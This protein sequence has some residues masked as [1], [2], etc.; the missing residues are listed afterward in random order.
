MLMIFSNTIQHI[1]EAALRGQLMQPVTPREGFKTWWIM[2]SG[3][4]ATGREVSFLCFCFD[5]LLFLNSQKE[6]QRKSNTFGILIYYFH[7]I[8]LYNYLNSMLILLK[9]KTS[10][11]QL[12]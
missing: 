7:I 8:L 5:S 1:R 6:N 3:N 12:Q 4:S 11:S 10:T 2:A 9:G